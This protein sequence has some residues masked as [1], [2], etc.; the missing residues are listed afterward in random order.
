MAALAGMRDLDVW[1]ARLNKDEFMQRVSQV[2]SK[3]QAEADEGWRRQ[4]ADEGQPQGVCQADRGRGRG[5]AHRRHPPLIVPIEEVAAGAGADAEQIEEY[6]QGVL[7]SYRETL[8]DDHRRLL[9]GFRYAHAARKVV[10]VGSV[11]SRAWIALLLG[12]DVDDPL[13]LQIKEARPSVLEPFLGESEFSQ[14]RTGA[15][16]RGSG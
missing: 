13:F 15:S 2:A 16:S 5:A 6:V 7:P 12:R 4:G 10:G 1:Y 14:P 11:G 9:E 8:T 3:K